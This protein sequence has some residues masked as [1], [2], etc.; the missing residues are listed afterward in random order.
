MSR[1]SIDGFVIA[2]YRSRRQ[3]FLRLARAA[4]NNGATIQPADESDRS[5]SSIAQ[6]TG[7]DTGM[8]TVCQNYYYAKQQH[9]YGCMLLKSLADRLSYLGFIEIKFRTLAS[10]D[11]MYETVHSGCA[12]RPRQPRRAV[13]HAARTRTPEDKIG[14]CE[15][16]QEL[17]DLAIKFDGNP[18]RS[19]YR[20]R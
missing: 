1:S 20:I 18:V 7:D 13:D 3:D 14:G 10:Y 11:P 5:A 16:S 19:L 9:P 4:I 6:K 12:R 8:T 17:S 15:C 2:W